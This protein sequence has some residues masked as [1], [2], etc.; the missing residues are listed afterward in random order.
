M[1]LTHS[2][3]EAHVQLTATGVSIQEDFI[4]ADIHNLV[5][6]PSFMLIAAGVVPQFLELYDR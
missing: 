2:Q 1:S 3:G 5:R 4:R 6:N